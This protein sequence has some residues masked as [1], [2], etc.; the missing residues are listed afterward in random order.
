MTREMVL[1]SKLKY[2][3]LMKHSVTNDQENSVDGF[4]NSQDKTGESRYKF[5]DQVASFEKQILK[6]NQQCIL[7]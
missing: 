6:E 4:L 2:E 1:I 7:H 5:G 3:H